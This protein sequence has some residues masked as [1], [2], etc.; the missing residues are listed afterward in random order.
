M[1]M[2]SPSAHGRNR[3]AE[4]QENIDCLSKKFGRAVVSVQYRRFTLSVS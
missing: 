3:C 4:L 1:L 2:G